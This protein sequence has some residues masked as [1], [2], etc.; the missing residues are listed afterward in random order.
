M[1]K[2]FYYLIIAIIAITAG[3]FLFFFRKNRNLILANVSGQ[4]ILS[5]YYLSLKSRIEE[6]EYIPITILNFT[7]NINVVEKGTVITSIIFN[8]RFN[9]VPVSGSINNNVGDID[10]SQTSLIKAVNLTQ[11]TNF[12]LTVSDGKQTATRTS[13]LLFQNKVYWGVSDNDTLTNEQILALSNSVLTTTKTRNYTIAG[14]GKKLV[15]AVPSSFG[16]V[17]FK[18]GGFP[19]TALTKTTQNI[20]NAL[21]YTTSY[22]IYV[23]DT[24]QFGINIQVEAI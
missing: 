20:T 9:K 8:F 4:N 10:I 3:I 6:L 17:S 21:G 15:Y 19:F 12:T 7:N 22:D 24:V 23:T 1:N 11:N 14:E 2:V 16:N 5:D 13:S 18:L